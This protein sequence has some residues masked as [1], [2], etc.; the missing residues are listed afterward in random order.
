MADMLEADFR[1]LSVPLQRHPL[2][3]YRLLDD[4]GREQ[5]SATADLLR[6]DFQPQASHRLLLMIHYDTVYPPPPVA[7][8][9]SEPNGAWEAVA[10][11]GR[12]RAPGGADAK[13]GLLV[14]RE[15]LLA[16]RK[17]NLDA[18]IGW[19]AW[20]NP[21]EEIGSPAS[22]PLMQSYADQFDFAL[23][24]EP[25]LP[26]GSLVAA[27]K[28]SG[29]FTL[30]VHG[31]SA[32]AGRN[33]GEGRNAIVHLSKLLV[34]VAGLNESLA[35]TTINVGRIAGGEAL[36]RVP[37]RAVGKFNVR[38][39][40]AV[41]GEILLNRLQ[42]LVAQF[43]GDGFRVELEGG[44]TS[45]AKP[46]DARF[47]QLQLRVAQARS[48]CGQKTEW[49]DTG[50]ACDGSKLAAFGLPNVDSL[51]PTGDCLHSPEEWVNLGSILPAAKTVVALI[52]QYAAEIRQ[53]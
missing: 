7:L 51:G 25:S 46:A 24:F 52:T 5:W 8:S 16:V 40:D 11:D 15:A 48:L 22:S 23:L 28:G 19:S 13:G 44:F 42:Q 43:Q 12:L 3:A 49:R 53:G 29:N 41:A 9:V 26:D 10:P 2:P 33:P 38:I 31:R 34:A 21:D 20:A 4:L 14:M 50:G 18:G 1:C 32:H 45:P 17:F 47:G 37:D 36:N 6:W 35:P 39:V 30:I 27:R